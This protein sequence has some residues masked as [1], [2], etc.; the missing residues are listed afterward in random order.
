[1]PQHLLLPRTKGFV[2]CVQKLRK[3][4]HV[5]AVYDIT[6]SYA[7]NDGSIFQHAPSFAESLM[8]P[9]LDRQWRFFVHVDRHSINELPESDEGIAQWLEDRWVEKGERLEVLHQK[10]RLG[11]PWDAL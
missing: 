9:R 3:T 1:M 2:A 7:R 4:T 5:K 10:L 11:L 6:V 8:I